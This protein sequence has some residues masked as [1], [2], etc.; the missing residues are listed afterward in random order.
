MHPGG[1]SDSW[2]RRELGRGRRGRPR[3]TPRAGRARLGVGGRAGRGRGV[4]RPSPSVPAAL[5]RMTQQPKQ[6]QRQEEAAGGRRG[7][8]GRDKLARGEGGGRGGLGG[9]RSRGAGDE[10]YFT[11]PPSPPTGLEG[12][13]PA[14]TSPLVGRADSLTWRERESPK[15]LLRKGDPPRGQEGIPRLPAAR[16]LDWPQ[17]HATSVNCPPNLHGHSKSRP[18][19]QFTTPPSIHPSLCPLRAHLPLVPRPPLL[20]LPPPHPLGGKLSPRAS[21][22]A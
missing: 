6:R 21:A 22:H 13:E 12:T 15:P 8:E 1:A 17:P 16:P 4:P 5:G 7:G 10:H 19:P 20:P 2:G 14:A 9:R 18:R 3:R 11:P